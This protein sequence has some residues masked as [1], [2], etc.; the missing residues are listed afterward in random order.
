MEDCLEVT[1]L[2][3]ELPRVRALESGLD[4]AT[5]QLV[6]PKKTKNKQQKQSKILSLLF[7][8]QEK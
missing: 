4:K 2:P 8:L 7:F 3:N 1:A 6:A 5:G